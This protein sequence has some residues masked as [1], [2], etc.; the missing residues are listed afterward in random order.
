MPMLKVNILNIDNVVI[1]A[2]VGYKFK[3]FIGKGIRLIHASIHFVGGNAPNIVWISPARKSD[4]TPN[5][6]DAIA[7]C[8]G[9]AV[10]YGNE[11]TPL[12]GMPC[13]ERGLVLAGSSGTTGLAYAQIFYV[14]DA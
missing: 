10:A 11:E 6:G 7:M 4:V 2:A 8:V 5:F 13:N 14:A 12:Y 1:V 9:G 3:P